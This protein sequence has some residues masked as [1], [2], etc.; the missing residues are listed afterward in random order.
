MA[1]ASKK[2]TNFVP[3]K[4]KKSAQGRSSM[5]KLSATSSRPRL[6]KYRGQGK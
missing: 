5:T 3:S 2:N 6:K 4:P 1:A